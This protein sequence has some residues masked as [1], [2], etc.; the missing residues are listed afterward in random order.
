MRDCAHAH[1]RSSLCMSVKLLACQGVVD[2]G[3]FSRRLFIAKCGRTRMILSSLGKVPGSLEGG[4]EAAHSVGRRCP[5][6]ACNRRA[7]SPGVSGDWAIV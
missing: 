6:V 7:A 1:Q 2:A 5:R 4:A 3:C